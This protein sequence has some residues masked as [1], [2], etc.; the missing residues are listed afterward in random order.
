MK[1]S[2]HLKPQLFVCL[3]IIIVFFPA[4]AVFCQSSALLKEGIAQ[5]RQENYEEAIV[6]LKK[7]REEEPKSSM[8]AFY[9]G[10]AYKQTSDIQNALPNFRDAVTLIPPVKEAVV[11][12]I[13]TLRQTGQGEEAKK[14]ISLAEREDIEPAK[15][16]FLKGMILQ[17]E[18][19]YADAAVAF[20]KA[21]ELDPAYGQSANF[22]IGICRMGQRD[23][24]KAKESFDAAI[25]QDPLSDLAT[26]ARRYLDVAEERRYLERPLRLTISL[27][28]QYDTN[29]LAVDSHAGAPQA[30]NI[31]TKTAD[32]ESY[33]MLSTV[34]L[35]YVPV[36]AGPFIF[37]ASYT[38]ASSLHEK[39]STAY[40]TMANSLTIAPGVTFE[41]FA[42]NL[43]GNYTHA[44]RRDPGYS[45]YSENI[46]IGPL[47]RYLVAPQHIVQLYAAFTKKNYFK[48]AINPELEDMSSDGFDS[49][50]NWIWL[51]R[52]EGVLSVK[53]GYTADNADGIDYD[54][55]G[56]RFSANLIYPVW[57]EVKLQLTADAYLQDYCHDNVIYEPGKRKDRIYTGTVG[58][59]WDIRKYASLMVQY[60]RT[61]ADSNIYA[62]DYTRDVYSVGVEFKF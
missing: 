58:L 39:N 37:N 55:R 20:Q 57:K 34:R 21:K 1:K 4:S 2:I 22:Q 19:K 38:A 36:L 49:Y 7:A 3:I 6:I 11:E 46:S 40:D 41:N 25:T 5:Y 9:L 45:P 24:S 33:A 54:N 27:M 10:L 52:Q 29:M 30:W 59:I 8:A 53:Y 16:A 61:E 56:H 12:F 13:D 14:W 43:V 48:P 18:T 62:Y 51:L 31:Y 35:D 26:F 15:V 28:G 44:L 32:K 42:V 47:F 50:I 17:S 23:Y 60:M